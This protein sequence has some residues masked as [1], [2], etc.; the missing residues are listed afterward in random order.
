[1]LIEDVQEHKRELAQNWQEMK[2]VLLQYSPSIFK[3][4][5]LRTDLYMRAFALVCTRAFGA[6]LPCN[7]LV[8]MA[9]NFNH[10]NVASS[11]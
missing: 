3:P 11:W 9:D 1:M 2:A 10:N 7:M 6:D 5:T 4:E 8:P